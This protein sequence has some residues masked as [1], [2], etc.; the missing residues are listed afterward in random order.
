MPDYRLCLFDAK[1][2][3][4][5]VAEFAAM[6]DE[7]ARHMSEDAAPGQDAQL[8]RGAV[9]VASIPADGREIASTSPDPA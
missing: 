9:L 1:G 6:D 7:Q 3:M 2:A 8:W 4:R 5:S